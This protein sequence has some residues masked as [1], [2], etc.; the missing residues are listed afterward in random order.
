MIGFD[1]PFV[2]IGERINPTGRKK[3]AEEM[4]AGNY[5]TVLADAVAQVEAGAQMLDVNAGIPLADEPAILAEAI[6]LVQSVTEVPLCIDSS[7]VAALEAGLGV[8][9]GKA[10]VNSVTGEE[11]RLESVLPLVA[12]HGAAVVA[13]TNDEIGD[14]GRPRR[15][16]RGRAR[17]VSRAADHGIPKEDVVVDPLVMP[18]GALGGAG[19]QVFRIVRRLREELGVNSTCGASNVSF[20]LPNRPALNASLPADGDRVRP[21]VGDHEPAPSRDAPGRE[22]RRRAD[23]QRR[24]LR[25]LD[26]PQRRLRRNRGDTRAPRRSRRQAEGGSHVTDALV[27]FTPSGRR[28]QFA[29]GTTVLDAARRLGVDLDSVCGGRGICGRCQV[30]V[31]EGEHAKHGIVSA[32]DHL[33]PAGELERRYAAE[34]GLAEGRRL[35]CTANV[36]GDLVIDVPPESQLYRQVVRKEADAR[37]V[38]IDPVVRLYY[39]EV[40]EAELGGSTGDLRRLR[41]AL[42]S[43]W[44]LETLDADNSVLPALQPALHAGDGAVTVAVHDGSTI[45]AVWPGLH[46]RAYGIAFDVGS[47]T[48]AGHLCDL[49]TGDVLASAGEMNPQIRFG[50]DLMSRV[51]YVMLHPGSEKELTRTVRGCLAKL[52]AELATSAGV[53]RTDVLEVTLVGNPIMHHLLL[54]IDPTPLGGAPFPLAVD[55]A[56]RLPAR[57]LG[58]P[59][60]PGAR[61]YVLPCIAGHVGA[62]TAGVVLSEAPHLAD[63]V[64]L[65]VDVGTNAEIVLGNR[66]RLLAASSPTGPAFEGA[67]I[68]CGQRAAPGAIERVRIDPETLEP[69]I[70]VIGTDAW[71]DEPGFAAAHVTGVCGSGIIEAIAE[72]HLA[73]ILTTDG[74]IDGS[75]AERSSRVVADGRTF[76]YVLWRGEPELVITQ[77]DVRQIQLAKAA[78]H[79]G[80]VLLME[81]YGIDCVDRIRL[82]GAFGAHIDPVHALVL[83]LVPDCNPEQ[84]TSAGNAAGTGARIALLNRAARAE[85]EDVVRRIEKVETAVEPRF[86]EHFVGAMAIPHDVDPYTRLARTVRL[87]KRRVASSERPQRQRRRERRSA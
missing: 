35:G 30:E 5:E 67:Q 66:E 70:R 51:S 44:E 4:A 24:P 42:A 50:E 54:G 32:A 76:S 48:V 80:C 19:R 11:D 47:T 46:D 15:A 61:A 52:T 13:I 33:S 34:R 71:S 12:K 36:T 40:P 79:A 2:I 84:V 17:I 14:L 63:D 25:E 55:E 65:L 75:F 43:E 7:I 28:G 18:I 41:E 56:L 37:P 68:S 16:V 81:R 22:G 20:G 23:G 87:P 45:T 78:L 60:H 62:D 27:V 21:H 59:V 69:R 8:Y 86:Q 82:A 1:R 77:S 38:D 31:S 73:G 9:Q 53:E 58:L 6:Q 29:P 39:V 57:E 10:L 64:S 49:T 72:L 85:I 83:G 74:T 26:R 3:L